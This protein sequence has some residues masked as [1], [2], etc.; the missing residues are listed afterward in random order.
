MEIGAAVCT[1]SSPGVRPVP[2]GAPLCRWADAAADGPDPAPAG[3]RQT[4]FEGSDRQGRG[5]LV[6]ALRLRP[7]AARPVAGPAC[8]WPDD[9][10]RA[11]PGGRRGSWPRAWPAGP[12]ATCWS[13]PDAVGTASALTASRKPR[14]CAPTTSG[15]SRWRKCPACSTIDVLRTLGQLGAD[16]T[17]GIEAQAPSSAPCRYSVGWGG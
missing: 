14:S 8:G 10:E 5:R 12:G 16:V 1:R 9:P 7:G 6:D 2:A 17:D 15:C 4:R 3:P 11:R 13:F